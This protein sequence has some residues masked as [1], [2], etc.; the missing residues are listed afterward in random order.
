MFR[1]MGNFGHPGE[2]LI[3]V[4]DDSTLDLNNVKIANINRYQSGG[5]GLEYLYFP[6]IEGI[7]ANLNIRDSIIDLF[8]S[9]V[10]GAA[11]WF[12]GTANVVSTVITGKGLSIADTSAKQGVMNVVNSLFWPFDHSGTARIQAY[13]GGEAN[14][15]ASTIQFDASGTTDVPST[16]NPLASCPT[17]YRC[18]GAPLQAFD[19]GMINLRSS[20]V[21]DLSTN[22]AG[23]L[24]PY[25]DTYNGLTGTL[26]ADASTFVQPVPSQDSAALK[27]LF[28]QISLLTEGVPYALN[29]TTSL[30]HYL[31]YPTGAYPLTS[32]PLLNAVA[33]A[34]G[35]NQLINPINGSVIT[36]DVFGNP[37]TRN[38][39]RDAGAVQANVPGPLPV[40]GCG[41]A[42]AWSRR[43]RRRIRKAIG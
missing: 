21:S 5:T 26:T 22:L 13:R 23:I 14:I 12:G 42:F 30:P 41:G 39:L 7:N 27:A 10:A 43:F 25:S 20:S 9:T 33:D 35:A 1:H 32:G 19:G 4:F 2:A 31:H 38:G 16:G 11:S 24:N 17:D 15:T 18:N 28:N 8:S 40:L 29:H 37:R 6:V 36:R 3:S 34:D